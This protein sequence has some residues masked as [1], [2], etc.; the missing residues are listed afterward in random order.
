MQAF[1][2]YIPAGARASV[3]SR[4]AASAI[5][6]ARIIARLALALVAVLITAPLQR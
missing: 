2:A 4:A 1:G 3:S 6:A 5:G